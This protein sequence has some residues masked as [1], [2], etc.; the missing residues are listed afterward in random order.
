M[1]H[2]PH[3]AHIMDRVLDPLVACLNREAA[4]SILELRN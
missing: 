3:V 4:L 2:A 1:E